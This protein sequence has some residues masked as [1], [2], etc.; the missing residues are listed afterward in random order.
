MITA[1]FI[2]L[3]LFCCSASG[4]EA[5]PM[6]DLCSTNQATRDAAAKILRETYIPPARTN[7]DS[8]IASL[9]VGMSKSKS[10]NCSS[11]S[12]CA[13]KAEPEAAHLRP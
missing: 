6:S 7:W 12:L 2:S 4:L 3:V 11:L 10:C 5:S 1:R 8:L 9:K 13:R